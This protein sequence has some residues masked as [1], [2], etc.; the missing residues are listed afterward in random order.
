MKTI[1]LPYQIGGL[2]ENKRSKKIN[3]KLFSQD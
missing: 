1:N 2:S 3:K